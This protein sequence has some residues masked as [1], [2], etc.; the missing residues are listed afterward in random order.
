MNSSIG[1]ASLVDSCL[2][3]E[4]FSLTYIH[5]A[6]S[7]MGLVCNLF[8]S[9]VFMQIMRN[10][11]LDS[12]MFKYLFIKSVN[13][14]L[15]FGFHIFSPLFYS[16]AEQKKT[17]VGLLW[18]LRFYGYP[19][20]TLNFC[21]SWMEVLATL[22]LFNL[23]TKKLSVIMSKW[24]FASTVTIIHLYSVVFH[25]Y[26]LFLFTI[27]EHVNDKSGRIEYKYEGTDFKDTQFHL[28][29]DLVNTLQRDLLVSIALV[30]LNCLILAELT[31]NYNRKRRLFNVNTEMTGNGS[32]DNSQLNSHRVLQ[33]ADNALRRQK[34]MILSVN[35]NYFFG[36][37]G[38]FIYFLSINYFT[39]SEAQKRSWICFSEVGLVLL[40]ISYTNNLFI[41]YAFNKH[42]ALYTH[43]N[44]KYFY[45]TSCCKK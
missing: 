13:D 34:L 12:H 14:F 45:E 43:K 44:L 36:H 8:G 6:I 2:L 23:I 9:V 42:F 20:R 4:D 21:S 24:F 26:I 37:M 15:Q 29:L 31:S 18:Y 32:S 16:S 41:F 3:G 33:N 10:I 27:K 28:V 35:L 17:F 30:V 25:L 5:P 19:E 1:N 40:Y 38:W 22:D 11:R 7:F 39:M